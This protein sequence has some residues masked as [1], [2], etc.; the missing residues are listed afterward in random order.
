MKASLVHLANNVNESFT[1][2]PFRIRS[3]EGNPS[4][5]LMITITQNPFNLGYA[6]DEN[7]NCVPCPSDKGFI[8][9]NGRCICDSARGLVLDPVTGSCVCPPGQELNAQGVCEDLPECG[10][11]PNIPRDPDCHTTKYCEPRNL[12]CSD[13]CVRWPCGPNAY[14]TPIN[15]R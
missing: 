3:P 4:L 5:P 1:P 6:F 10:I 7:G 8:I 14:G 11:R 12:T 9:V 13:P 15:H 2:L